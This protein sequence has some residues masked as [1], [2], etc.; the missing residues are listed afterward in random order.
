VSKVFVAARPPVQVDES[1]PWESLRDSLARDHSRAGLD[2]YQFCFPSPHV[3]DVPRLGEYA[4][5]SF[6]EGRPLAAGL[7]ELTG[8]IHADFAYDPAATNI[9]T[10]IDEVFRQRRGVCQDLAHVQIGCLRSLGLAARYVSGYLRTY[11]P[12]G[13]PRL[14]GADASHAWL[15]VHAGPLG[16]IDVD[17][18]NNSLPR[19]EHITI[20]WGRDYSDVCPISGMFTGGGRHAMYVSVDVEPMGEHT[21]AH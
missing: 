5:A 15:S 12:P 4:R 17:P 20:A 21:P 8:R 2:V 11:P 9:S 1:L 18:T 19:D 3:P 14:V 13:K 7:L 16:W 10:P 6:P